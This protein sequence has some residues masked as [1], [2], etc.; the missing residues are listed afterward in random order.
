MRAGRSQSGFVRILIGPGRR[1][2]PHQFCNTE[3]LFGEFIPDELNGVAAGRCRFLLVLREEP[4][5]G[6][7]PKIVREHRAHKR[8]IEPA[9]GNEARHGPENWSA[10]RAV[11][12]PLGVDSS[13]VRPKP[14]KPCQICNGLSPVFDVLLELNDPY[15]ILTKQVQPRLDLRGVSSPIQKSGVLTD[16]PI[17]RIG[18][19]MI[20]EFVVMMRYDPAHRIADEIDDFEIR[21]AITEDAPC[22]I[23]RSGIVGELCVIR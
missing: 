9:L 12:D 22:S 4:L 16:N 13:Q 14:E 20:D 8:A 6:R 18:H 2:P 5:S 17:D 10:R 7:L 19:D 1:L 21:D 3:H 11:F 23:G 15:S